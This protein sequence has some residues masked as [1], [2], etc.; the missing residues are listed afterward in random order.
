MWF[1]SSETIKHILYFCLVLVNGDY[2]NRHDV[3]AEVVY[4]NLVFK[5][6]FIKTVALNYSF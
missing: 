4:P 6:N 2:K 5:F 1:N 3:V